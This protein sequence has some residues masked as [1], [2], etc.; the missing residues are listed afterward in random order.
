MFDREK[1]VVAAQEDQ[2]AYAKDA[3]IADLEETMRMLTA[4]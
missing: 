4:Y 3:E 2:P 1:R